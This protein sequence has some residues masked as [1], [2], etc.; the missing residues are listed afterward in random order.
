MYVPM[1]TRYAYFYRSIILEFLF[2]DFSVVFYKS[3]PSNFPSNSRH[4]QNSSVKLAELISLHI[5]S[6]ILIEYREFR[7]EIVHL[8]DK[9]FLNKISHPQ[10]FGLTRSF[11]CVLATLSNNIWQF[12]QYICS[13]VVCSE[14]TIFGFT[15]SWEV[16]GSQLSF[17]VSENSTL[18]FEFFVFSE[19]FEFFEPCFELSGSLPGEVA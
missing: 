8:F 6:S 13:I 16:L 1:T 17:S 19:F 9:N 11:S 18:F 4:T 15:V 2:L 14:V 5:L 12:W 7:R 10:Q 3:Y